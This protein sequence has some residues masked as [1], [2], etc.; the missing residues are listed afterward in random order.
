MLSSQL[1]RFGN[2]SVATLGQVSFPETADLES[3]AV[4]KKTNAIGG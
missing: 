1:W 4:V 3:D 2:P